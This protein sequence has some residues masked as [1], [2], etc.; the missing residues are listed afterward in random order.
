MIRTKRLKTLIIDKKNNYNI[1]FEGFR[2]HKFT[3]NTEPSILNL[4]ENELKETDVFF[5]VVYELKDIIQI[6]K[7]GQICKSIII[8]TVNKRLYNSLQSIQDYPVIDLTPSFHLKSKLHDALAQ[9]Y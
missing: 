9:F 5:V 6:V 8:G 1:Y 2:K 4:S 7:L 3:F